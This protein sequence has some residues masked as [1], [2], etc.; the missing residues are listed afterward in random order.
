MLNSFQHSADPEPS[1]ELVQA[2]CHAELVS[3]SHRF[4][5]WFGM[6]Y[7][8]MYRKIIHLLHQ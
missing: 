5:T 7:P 8:L 2:I 1:I 6:T 4:R 3:A